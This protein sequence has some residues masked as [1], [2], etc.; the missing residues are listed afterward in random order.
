MV[1]DRKRYLNAFV[2]SNIIF[3]SPPSFRWQVTTS[4]V[5]KHDGSLHTDSLR[6]HLRAV[7]NTAATHQWWSAFKKADDNAAVVRI[8][9][10]AAN[11]GWSLARFV[12][13]TDLKKPSE[14][15]RVVCFRL[16]ATISA[17]AEVNAGNLRRRAEAEAAAAVAAQRNEPV[18][19]DVRRMAMNAARVAQSK[20]KQARYRLAISVA[21]YVIR[22]NAPFRI[23]DAEAFRDLV[24]SI[25]SV[26]REAQGDEG[27]RLDF[28]SRKMVVQMVS[29]IYHF[30]VDKMTE[31][32]RRAPGFSIEADPW[33]ARRVSLSMLP[34][35]YSVVDEKYVLHKLMIDCIPLNGLPHD[36]EHLARAIARRVDSH[37]NNNAL[38][39]G[40]STDGARNVVAMAQLLVHHYEAVIEAGR[41]ELLRQERALRAPVAAQ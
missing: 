41:D 34:I 17:E 9:D 8:L 24:R 32:L 7:H 16:W 37:S 40:V 3:V 2:A 14:A 36:H 6:T 21:I 23:A 13:N 4:S 10:N 15:V 33:T 1:Y 30:C 12:D 27:V 19:A 31:T 28:P 22:E 11:G 39:V 20:K 25:V 29:V 35:V 18:Q 5:L 26:D 38:L